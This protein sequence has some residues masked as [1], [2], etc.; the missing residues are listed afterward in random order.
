MQILALTKILRINYRANILHINYI[1]L[2]KHN[3][4]QS[5]RIVPEDAAQFEGT[6]RLADSEDD[7]PG[8]SEPDRV[9]PRTRILTKIINSNKY[10]T[11][12]GPAQDD[13]RGTRT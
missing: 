9:E 7:E 8:I 2:N 13:H 12:K 3:R 10:L 6:S 4:L 5:K 11:K 1:V